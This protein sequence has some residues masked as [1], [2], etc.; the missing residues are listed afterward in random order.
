[1]TPF[2][3]RALITAAAAGLLLPG[4]ARAATSAPWLAYD[5]RLRAQMARSR[6]DFDPEFEQDLTDLGDI[7]RRGRGLRGL[8]PD[9]GLTLAARAHAADIARTGLFDH[10]TREGYGPAARVGLLARDLV[11]APG[12]NIAERLNA[13]G[14]VR[15]D[16][17]MGQWKTS[18]GH[19]ANLLAPGF[20]HVGY[21][22]L[23]QGREV[24]AV[25]AY[26]EV[27]ARLASPAPLRVSS[28]D[29]IAAVLA[30]ATPR[31]DQ[32]SVSEPGAEALVETY[33]EGP[34]PPT[35]PPG[36]WQIRPHLS[37]GERRYQVAWGPVFVLG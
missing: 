17:I 14:P 6:G 28:V 4:L 12:E 10:M 19:R 15:P 16:Q 31:I 9:P 5:R 11:G 25:G 24:I 37:T 29:A 21:G 27:S 36:A 20:T 30:S 35:L 8:A 33:L 26:A 18:P 2:D 23:R 32:F 13:S 22:V 3:R 34:R 1:M 7:F